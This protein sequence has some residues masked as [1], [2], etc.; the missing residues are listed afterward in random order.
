M[1]DTVAVRRRRLAALLLLALPLLAA[2]ATAGP[3]GVWTQITS[4][5]DRNIDEVASAR[6]A[7]GVL[8]FV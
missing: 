6:T 5:T 3:P 1:R 2:S 8:H 4:S 7:D